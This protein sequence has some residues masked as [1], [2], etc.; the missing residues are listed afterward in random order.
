M[1]AWED[2]DH[3]V[4][5]DP[6]KTLAGGETY[7]DVAATGTDAIAVGGTTGMTTEKMAEVIEAVGRYDVPVFIEPSHSATVVHVDALD[8]YLVPVVFNA[9]DVAWMTGFHKE[10]VRLDGD[11]DWSRT[12]TEAYVVMNPDSS[13]AQYTDANCDLR[14]DEVA[15]YATVAERM[16]GQEIVYV[17]YSGTFGDPELVAAAHGALEE[18]TLFY[19]GGIRDYDSARR[20]AAVADVV[21]V[22]DLVHEAGVDAVTETVRGANDAD[23]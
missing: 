7:A 8:G 4:K 3:V 19:G 12:A 22:G 5:L 23:A 15:A 14:P 6:D 2:W 9:G 17:E 1:N 20:M 21:V 18:A 16:F 10:W 11:I 13:V